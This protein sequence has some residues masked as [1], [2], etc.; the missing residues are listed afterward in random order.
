MKTGSRVA[1]ALCYAWLAIACDQALAQSK[2]PSR[3]IRIVAQE[4]GKSFAPV[5]LL[6]TAPLILRVTNSLPVNSIKELIN[7]AR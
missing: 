3:P 6:A 2:Y 4:L 5:S 1:R 7:G